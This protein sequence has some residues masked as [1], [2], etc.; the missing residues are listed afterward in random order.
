[1]KKNERAD[2][3]LI[4]VR[5]DLTNKGLTAII[6][7]KM[8]QSFINHGVTKVDTNPELEDNQQVQNLWKGYEM[9]LH[10]RRKC[11]SKRL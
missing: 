10:K 3:Y 9:R 2:L 7:E 11:Y 6:F 1:M 5:P 8:I 4:A